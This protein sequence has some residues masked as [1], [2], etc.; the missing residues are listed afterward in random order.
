LTGWT[1]Y[2]FSSDNVAASQSGRSLFLPRLEVKDRLGNWKTVIESI[3]ISVGRPQTI[4][5]DL[6]GK[7]L[8]D[9]R[10]VRIVTNVKTYWDKVE[11]DTSEQSP[12]KETE[13]KPSSA[14]LS[15]RGFSK[16]ARFGGMIVP[17]YSQI[18]ND[19]R[20][21]YFSGRF[22][23]L[24][25]VRVLLDNIDDIFVI[26]KTGDELTLRFKPPAP[27]NPGRK[28]TFLLFAD[29][30]SKEMDINS[31]SPEA[32]FPASVQRML[33]YP[34]DSNQAY[35]WSPDKQAFTTNTL[36][37]LSTEDCRALKRRY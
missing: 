21:K 14:E 3:G 28:F 8:S 33:T 37:G 36:H 1:D 11:V 13:I 16:E 19:G 24:G 27:L 34:Y 5:V 22:T 31:G 12:V 29:G 32:V 20:W 17:D 25:D 15:E 35:P 10:Q 9:S 26:S 30:Y 6:T 18:V 23:K 2:A 7:F 4:A